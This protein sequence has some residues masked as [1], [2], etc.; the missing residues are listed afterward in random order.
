[1]SHGCPGHDARK[2]TRRRE[3]YIDVDVFVS[4]L[5]QPERCKRVRCCEDLG[6]IDVCIRIEGEGESE[7]SAQFSASSLP[8]LSSHRRT[9]LPHPY[10]FQEFQLVHS[11]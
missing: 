8:I 11:K 6:L 4:G 10:A 7:G 2:D 3:T 9:D 1:M 5:V